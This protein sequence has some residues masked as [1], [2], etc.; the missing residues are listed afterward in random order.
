MINYPKGEL[1]DSQLLDVAGW[2]AWGTREFLLVRVTLG[3]DI[4]NQ[5]QEPVGWLEYMI[6]KFFLNHD[7]L[8][9]VLTA[10]PGT[11]KVL[12]ICSLKCLWTAL[13]LS[14]QDE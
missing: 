9:A 8:F 1:P 2:I 14:C 4:K 6:L 3:G 11:Q 10:M 13:C 5:I 12:N 7:N